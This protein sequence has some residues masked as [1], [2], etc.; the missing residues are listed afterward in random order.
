LSL[1]D[2]V[3]I[4][5]PIDVAP[6]SP[7]LRLAPDDSPRA[8]RSVAATAPVIRLG[9]NLR[10]R[11]AGD[12]PLIAYFEI[13]HLL[14]GV[15]GQ[16]PFEYEYTVRSEEKD[17]RPW[18]R[19]ILPFGAHEPRVQVQGAEVNFGPL[20]RQFVSVPVASLPPGR[21]RLEVRVRDVSTGNT[22]LGTVRFER[23]VAAGVEVR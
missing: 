5:G 1:S 15:N 10:A 7:E 17:A 12:E 21:Y 22:A 3:V 20:R 18:F 4:C 23:V 14:P 11:V 8:P 19:R 9:P 13:Y 2:V 16:A 6:G